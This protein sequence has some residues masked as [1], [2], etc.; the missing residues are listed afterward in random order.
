MALPKMIGRPLPH[1]GRGERLGF[2]FMFTKNCFANSIKK[3]DIRL[4]NGHDFEQTI[5]RTKNGTLQ[6]YY[7]MKGLVCDIS[8]IDTTLGRDL[9]EEVSSGTR[10]EMSISFDNLP[11]DEI[12]STASDGELIC[13]IQKGWLSEISVVTQGAVKGTSIDIVRNGISTGTPAIQQSRD[14]VRNDLERILQSIAK[15]EGRPWKPTGTTANDGHP[16]VAM[17][18]VYQQI[19]EAE[20]R[21]KNC[22]MTLVEA[23]QHLARATGTTYVA[24]SSPKT[25]VIRLTGSIDKA[26]DKSFIAELHKIGAVD[27]LRIFIDSCGGSTGAAKRIMAA[28][29]QHP[30]K[31]IVTI[32]C[33]NCYSAAANVF[34]VGHQRLMTPGSCL[35]LHNA[36]FLKGVNTFEACLKASEWACDE[37]SKRMPGVPRDLVREWQH[38][39]TYFN[40][41]NAI[42]FG[43]ATGLDE[44]SR[45]TTTVNPAGYTAPIVTNDRSATKAFNAKLTQR[46]V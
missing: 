12:W 3:D 40:P 44:T 42:K 15:A 6:V 7:D 4:C 18:R 33:G 25:G 17:A 1:G 34:L 38:C 45:E 8:P 26:D 28:I 10:N 32:A 39:D 43:L 27:E 41:A 29:Q 13:T 2:S 16:P 19:S 46:S 5:A 35:C 22:G 9:V 31:R 37:W 14:P 24:P 23:Q 36:V 21:V 20:K 11:E 30:A